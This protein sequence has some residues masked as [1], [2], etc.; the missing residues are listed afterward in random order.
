M[1]KEREKGRNE[2]TYSVLELSGDDSGLSGEKLDHLPDRHP[3]RESVRVHDHV[4]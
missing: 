3:G 2:G 4:S 1:G